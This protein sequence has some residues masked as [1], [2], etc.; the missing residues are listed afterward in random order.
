MIRLIIFVL[1]GYLL[2]RGLKVLLLPGTKTRDRTGQGSM[3]VIDEMVQD[4][5]C[6]KYIPKRESIRS[7]INGQEYFFCSQACAD[8]FEQ[9]KKDG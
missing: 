2:Y 4:P 7:T 3:K 6:E 8:R 1:I 5:F 9:M